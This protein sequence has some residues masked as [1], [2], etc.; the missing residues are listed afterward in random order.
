MPVT[1]LKRKEKRNARLK[2]KLFDNWQGLAVSALLSLVFCCLLLYVLFNVVPSMVKFVHEYV[3]KLLQYFQDENAS[4][5]EFIAKTNNEANFLTLSANLTIA[6]FN[7]DYLMKKP[8]LF[9]ANSFTNKQHEQLRSILH[10]SN[11]DL[12]NHKVDLFRCEDNFD[13][14]VPLVDT[15]VVLLKFRKRKQPSGGNLSRNEYVL[16]DESLLR[17]LGLESVRQWGNTETV[18]ADRMGTVGAGGASSTN[19]LKA[20]KAAAGAKRENKG[21]SGYTSGVM[22]MGSPLRLF[23]AH[24]NHGP[25]FG[26][27]PSKQFWNE[28]IEGAQHW[29][30]EC[31]L[32]CM[33]K[34]LS[35]YAYVPVMVIISPI[36]WCIGEQMPIFFSHIHNITSIAHYQHTNIHH[37]NN[38]II[39]ITSTLQV[40]FPPDNA[41]PN[42]FRSH[43]SLANWVKDVYPG[44]TAK[45]A[46][47]EVVVR[48]GQVL[49]VNSHS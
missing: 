34:V 46:P 42:G 26:Q 4:K 45:F 44:I 27:S 39:I 32:C 8:V 6:V 29:V 11:R 15:D 12:R 2:K 48:P 38:I 9:Y 35:L 19:P 30:R 3:M 10:G 17:E 37:Y 41:P 28:V 49:Y 36:E 13:C 21:I 47:K 14:S 22:N 25:T 43:E 24:E 18:E 40:L 20:S 5:H 7:R 23:M 31:G 16:H 1:A 33:C